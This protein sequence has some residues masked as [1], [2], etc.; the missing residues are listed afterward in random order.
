MCW[1]YSK[2]QG[3]NFTLKRNETK[4]ILYYLVIFQELFFVF[5][6]GLRSSQSHLQSFKLIPSRSPCVFSSRQILRKMKTSVN[7]VA[8]IKNEQPMGMRG[9]TYVNGSREG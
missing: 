9:E 8:Y 1:Q 2:K 5:T 6:C 3:G 7:D 4:G